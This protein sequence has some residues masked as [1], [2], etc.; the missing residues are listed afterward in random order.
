MSIEINSPFLR[1]LEIHNNR[2]A[3]LTSGLIDNSIGKMMR[4]Q[5]DNFTQMFSLA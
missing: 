5:Q 3:K 4:E 2:I 1:A